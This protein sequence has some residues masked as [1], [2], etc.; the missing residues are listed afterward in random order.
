MNESIAVQRV[1]VNGADI[2]ALRYL[3]ILAIERNKLNYAVNFLTRI[4]RLGSDADAFEKLGD[5][6]CTLEKP[7]VG[8]VYYERAYLLRQDLS[9]SRLGKLVKTYKDLFYKSNLKMMEFDEHIRKT[10]PKINDLTEW[11]EYQKALAA[12]NYSRTFSIGLAQF[13]ENRFERRALQTW[14]SSAARNGKINEALCAALLAV[15]Y[16]PSNWTAI[17]NLADVFIQAHQPEK[18]IDFAVAAVNLAPEQATTWTNLGAAY[19][20]AWRPWESERASRRALEI[21]AKNPA[22]WTNLG[23]ALKN[24]GRIDESVPAYREA[25]RYAP[26]NATL[27][28]NYLF[29]MLYADDISPV[30]VAKEHFVYSEI[31]EKHL[32]ETKFSKGKLKEGKSKLKIGFVSSDFRSH[33]VSNF[34]EPLLTHVN[35]LQYELHV[36]NTYKRK[37]PVT[38]RL[39][40]LVPYWHDV[41]ELDVV[42]LHKKILNDDIDVLVDMTG[43]TAGNRLLTFARRAAPV[44]VTW[45][46]HPNT[47][48]LRRMDWRLTDDYCDPAGSD[49]RYS[50]KLWRLPVSAAFIPHTRTPHLRG[51]D[52]YNVA[53][54]PVMKNGYISF[55]CC[56]NVAKLSRRCLDVWCEIL[57][58]VPDSR[59][60]LESPGLNQNE[61]KNDLLNKFA[62]RGVSVDRIVPLDRDGALQYKRYNEIDIALDP[63]PYNGGTTSHDT[64]WMGVPLVALTGASC[65][66]RMG[67]MINS[68]LG[69]PERAATTESQYVDI[70]VALAANHSRLNDNRKK[71][72]NIVESSLLMNGVAYARSFETAISQ[73]WRL[74][75]KSA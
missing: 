47:T 70:A 17:V 27:R 12:T 15:Y 34:V 25:V 58:R 8:L 10:A 63:F 13:N 61:L 66:G 72:R 37:D 30:D 42:G 54:A 55:G 46:G 43:H 2:D 73:M 28:S 62:M 75:C 60:L 29:G 26:N 1:N 44:Q 65:I 74:A 69:F 33:P 22:A 14:A 41:A 53:E 52:E 45:L 35:N 11:S 39:S 16:E 40:K 36:Y 5:V 6:Y 67:Y 19:D 51:S 56:N 24:S 59:I 9:E 23:N 50:E 57:R 49:D 4:V 71:M 18:A 21:N 7:V 38:E 31:F 3:A 64:V 68:V 20:I 32:P 48:G